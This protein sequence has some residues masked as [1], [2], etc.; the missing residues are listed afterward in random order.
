MLHSCPV[1]DWEVSQELFINEPKSFQNFIRIYW[2]GYNE[3]MRD[4]SHV[5]NQMNSIVVGSPQQSTKQWVLFSP[6]WVNLTV[7]SLFTFVPRNTVRS[8][9]LFQGWHCTKDT[10]LDCV[11]PIIGDRPIFCVASGVV[12]KEKLFFSDLGHSILIFAAKCGTNYWCKWL[13]G[14]KI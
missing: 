11:Y 13:D 1:F 9:T 6:I 4:I 8:A 12:I 7:C 14:Q 10:I 2:H 5:Q 3:L